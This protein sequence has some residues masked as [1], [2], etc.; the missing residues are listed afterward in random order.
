MTKVAAVLML[1]ATLAACSMSDS[2]MT[3]GS[4]NSHGFSCATAADVRAHPGD[5]SP[6]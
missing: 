1:A 6:R 5:C 3:T 4:I 2:R